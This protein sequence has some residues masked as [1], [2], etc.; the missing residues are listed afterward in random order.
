[1]A[2]GQKL[3]EQGLTHSLKKLTGSKK[4]KKHANGEASATAAVEESAAATSKAD[5]SS[6]KS[7]QPT[8]SSSGIKN[9]STAVL[10]AKVLEEENERTKRIKVARSENLQGLFHSDTDKSRHHIKD[11][12]FMTRGFSIPT[13]ARR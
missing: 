7:K 4:R 6:T 12:D 11:G 13:N 2:R 10:T 5:S 3:A 1:M 8:S 9:A